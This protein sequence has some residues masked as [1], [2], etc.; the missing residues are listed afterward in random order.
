VFVFS[1]VAV[2][3]I[4]FF[5][6]E[7]RWEKGCLFDRYCELT[8]WNLKFERLWTTVNP[9]FKNTP[10]FDIEFSETIKDRHK[11]V[12]TDHSC[13]SDIIMWLIE[14]CHRQWPWVAVEGHF[15]YCKQFHCL[16]LKKYRIYNVRSESQQSNILAC[17]QLF[18][19]L[20]ST[21][22]LCDAELDLLAIAKFL[23][24]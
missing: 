14:L 2:D 18:L 6:W 24:L 15:S 12:T 7:V 8:L 13:K 9:D 5:C 17:E 23:V 16:R 4:I 11:I 20:N 10:L 19:L 1:T 21:G 3:N 22:L